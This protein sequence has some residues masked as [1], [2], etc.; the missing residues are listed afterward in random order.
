M[1][2]YVAGT[3]LYSKA[4]LISQSLRMDESDL[5]L[6]EQDERKYV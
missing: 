1:Y 3:P 6:A 2:R 5:T 4:C